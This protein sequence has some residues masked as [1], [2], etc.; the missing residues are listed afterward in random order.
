MGVAMTIHFLN[1]KIIQSIDLKDLAT[2]GA[3]QLPRP[4]WLGHI[5]DLPRARVPIFYCRAQG[6]LNG[7]ESYYCD[8]NYVHRVHIEAC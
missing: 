5:I 3:F 6:I 8:L 7:L 2:I 4:A 1:F